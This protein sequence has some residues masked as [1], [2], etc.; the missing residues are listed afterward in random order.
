MLIGVVFT[1]VVLLIDASLHSR[2]AN[3]VQ[4]QASGTWI[5]RVLPIITTSNAEG[6]QMSA[7]WTNGLQMS[8]STL[9]NDLTET[10][11]GADNTYKEVAAL[12]PPGVVAAASGLLEASLLE[13]SKAAALLRATLV[14]LLTG[15]STATTTTSSTTLP[16]GTVAPPSSPSSPT[17]TAL[18]TVADDLTIGDIAYQS[19]L[20]NLPKLGVKVPNSA[21]ASNLTPYQ[22]GAAQI[23]L[24]SLQ[25]AQ[26]TTPIHAVKIY[27][28]TTA[29]PAVSSQGSLEILPDQSSITV[30][31]VIADVGNQA[32]SD[33]NVLV[34]CISTAGESDARQYINLTPGQSY[35]V[36]GMGPLTTSLG[37]QTTLTVTVTPSASS[38]APPVT[39]TIQ[40]EM[41]ANSSSG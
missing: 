36:A 12:R 20:Q 2:S 29:P 16:A 35:S 10:A 7:V 4:Q 6:Q 26:T 23:F 25:N 1:L 22:P 19:F 5:D 27:S 11:N 40:F 31:V 24:T 32:E 9:A 38:G 15:S 13:R 41:P 8:G 37:V 34:T 30:S 14:P 21:W 33:L 39:Q 28:I 18:Q 17:I 3:P